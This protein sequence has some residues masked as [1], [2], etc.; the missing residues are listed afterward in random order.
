METEHL[1]EFVTIVDEGSFSKA[2]KTLHCTQPTLSKHM[3]ALERELACPLFERSGGKIH[4]TKS[5]RALYGY[6]ARVQQIMHYI[7]SDVGTGANS[8][9]STSSSSRKPSSCR[10]DSSLQNKV[11]SKF[12]KQWSLDAQEL[13][14]LKK[15]LSGQSLVEIATD[16]NYTRDDVAM[17]LGNVYRKTKTHGKQRLKMLVNGS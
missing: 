6:A 9:A 1:H 13:D 12:K 16:A 5:G 15:Y 7:Y 11:N 2:A 4:P 8:K 10:L 14:I 3:A 17:I